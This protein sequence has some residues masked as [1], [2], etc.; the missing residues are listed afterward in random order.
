MT[1]EISISKIIL[2]SIFFK[3]RDHL[4][5]IISFSFDNYLLYKGF[6]IVC[7][8]FIIR[9]I[10]IPYNKEKNQI[11]KNFSFSYDNIS[12]SHKLYGYIIQLSERNIF[13]RLYYKKISSNILPH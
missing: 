9:I 1:C 8:N 13:Q 11:L 3:G 2:Y 12:F 7:K 5:N 6:T 10:A 4:L